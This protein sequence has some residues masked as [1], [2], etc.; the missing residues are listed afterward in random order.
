MSFPE[1]FIR[2]PVIAVVLSLLLMIVG[3]F[4]FFKLEVRVWPSHDIPAIRITTSY[5][6]ASASL[7]ERSVTNVLEQAL[8][9]VPGIQDMRSDSKKNTSKIT[10]HLLANANDSEVLSQVREVVSRASGQLPDNIDAPVVVKFSVSSEVGEYVMQSNTMPLPKLMDYANLHI[11]PSLQSIA[12]VAAINVWGYGDY[13]MQINLDPQKMAANHVSVNEL[14]SAVRSANVSL[15]GGQVRSTMMNYPLNIN[16]RLNRPLEYQQIVIRNDQGHLTRVGDVANVVLGSTEDALEVKFNHQRVI[17]INVEPV[18][19]AN[20]VSSYTDLSQRMAL[21]QKHLPNGMHIFNAFNEVKYLIASINEVYIAIIVA[22]FCVLLVVFLFLGDWRS[23]LVPFACIPVSLLAAFFL[24]KV[25]GLSINQFTLLALVLAVGLVVDDAIV[26][27][28]NIQRYLKKGLSSFDASIKGSTQIV[29]PVIVMTVTLMAVYAPIALITGRYA[30]IYW[31]FAITLTSCVLVSGWVSL[32][33]SPLMCASL[34]KKSKNAW[35]KKI[36]H[37]LVILTQWYK[38][39]LAQ[40]MQRRL[41]V[42]SVVVLLV[43]LGG[44]AWHRLDRA[45]AP[46]ENYG[47]LMINFQ[48]KEGANMNATS[49]LSDRLA[50]WAEKKFPGDW[51]FQIS[52]DSG[53]NTGAVNVLTPDNAAHPVNFLK[54]LP[55]INKEILKIPGARIS[56]VVPSFFSN[57]HDAEVEF[58]ISSAQDYSYLQN[59]AQQVIKHLRETGLVTQAHTDLVFNSQQYQIDVNYA[60]ASDLGITNQAINDNLNAMFQGNHVS[61]FNYLNQSYDVVIRT[62]ASFRNDIHSLSRIGVPTSSGDVVPLSQLLA[63]K[64]VIDQPVLRHF[65]R[66]RSAKI[67]ASLAPGVSLS[68]VAVL[69]DK[70]LSQWLPSDVSYR[71]SGHLK[72]LSDS[73]SNMS[74]LFAMAV[75][76]IY[77]LLAM[78]FGNFID[79]LTVMFTVPLCVFGAILSLWLVGG[80]FNLYTTIALVTL[81]GLITKH[82]ILIVDFSNHYR[83]KHQADILTSVIEASAVRLRPILMT[84]SAMIFGAVPLV[85]S[86]GPGSVAR[87]QMGV[88]I[89][90]GLLVGTFFSLIVVPVTYSYLS[91]LKDRWSIVRG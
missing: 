50:N 26:V 47:I 80:S 41:W 38:Q 24:M 55:E 43:G 53:D 72:S 52:G 45:I 61:T 31:Q 90:G 19:N 65:N 67:Q 77:L 59:Q 2:K 88:V 7:V 37:Y 14:A 76:F 84:T 87:L 1:F 3:A 81:V 85:L 18:P 89:I 91:V 66:L 28:E 35:Q 27:L 6:G 40:A 34:L 49:L 54:N 13:E 20:V 44:V 86:S 63:V 23:V 36:D 60:L 74:Y 58:Y 10:L 29:F 82:G 32:T 78:Q 48:L 62:P 73:S 71:L 4:S 15:A 64:S 21:I 22:V 39:R 42:I 79:P 8:S 46:A 9:S 56:A 25:G 57:P 70:H 75:I 51:V 12:D 11:Q 16:T 5:S 68:Q 30:S 17:Y 83:Q 69:I 33:L